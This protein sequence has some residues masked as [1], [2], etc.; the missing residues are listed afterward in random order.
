MT[1]FFTRIW[2]LELPPSTKFTLMAI[3]RFAVMRGFCWASVPTLSA[4]TGFSDRATRRH[5]AELEEAGLIERKERRRPDGGR[6]SNV[7]WL[8][9]PEL[10]L[11]AME[12]PKRQDKV[13]DFLM[14]EDLT[15]GF[16]DGDGAAGP[17]PKRGKPPAPEGDGPPASESGEESQG[18]SGE[19]SGR[20]LSDSDESDASGDESETSS[21]DS[22]ESKGKAERAEANRVME[23]VWEASSMYARKRGTRE[24][25]AEAA[26]KAIKGGKVT[27][28]ELIAAWQA[29]TRSPDGSKSD[30]MYQKG[31]DRWIRNGLY[32]GWLEEIRAAAAPAAGEGST[33]AR[34]MGTNEEPTEFAQKIWMLSYTKRGTWRERQGPEPGE[35]GCRVTPEIQRE[36]GVIPW[37][38]R[39][40]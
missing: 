37:E 17:G 35:E 18:T 22:K 2:A 10:T 26:L 34:D 36:Y 23:A 19:S 3:G 25:T 15:D 7:I 39:A 13:G 33:G 29:Y 24:K 8:K 28:D 40:K 5:I 32:E 30:G 12:P 1:D 9:L 16:S 31:P 27:G 14:A 6:T 11:P 4:A 38:D 21:S 20:V